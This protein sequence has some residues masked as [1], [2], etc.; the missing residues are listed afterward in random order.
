MKHGRYFLELNLRRWGK[1]V[2]LGDFFRELGLGHART[3]LKTKKMS[4]LF[5]PFI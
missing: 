1:K 3:V 2:K 5:W 4:V